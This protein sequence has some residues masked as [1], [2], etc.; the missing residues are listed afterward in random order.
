MLM[1]L[2]TLSHRASTGPA[3]AFRHRNLVLTSAMLATAGLLVAAAYGIAKNLFVLQ[4]LAWDTALAA[5]TAWVCLHADRLRRGF[6][7]AEQTPG[8][9][10]FGRQ[11]RG[12]IVVLGG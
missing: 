4:A 2:N 9:D 12:E 7:L 11:I 5:L 8:A 6:A 1:S 10:L 3:L